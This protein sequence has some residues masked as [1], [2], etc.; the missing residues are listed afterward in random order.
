MPK[1]NLVYV[2]DFFCYQNLYFSITTFSSIRFSSISL[3]AYDNKTSFFCSSDKESQIPD[4]TLSI[5]L[6][7]I[8]ATKFIIIKVSGIRRC[9]PFLPTIAGIL[10]KKNELIRTGTADCIRRKI[11]ADTIPVRQAGGRDTR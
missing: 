6:F 5:L 8:K 4:Y 9:N 11:I 3:S 1:I 2:W 7:F 10:R